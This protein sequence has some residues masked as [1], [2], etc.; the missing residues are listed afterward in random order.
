M[1]LPKVARRWYRL[2]AATAALQPPRHTAAVRNSLT[3]L[4]LTVPA[5]AL[6][7][8]PFCQIKQIDFF[9]SMADYDVGLGDAALMRRVLSQSPNICDQKPGACQRFGQLPQNAIDA[10]HFPIST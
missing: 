4:L 6:L 1:A 3:S 10:R 9:L 2:L 7:L 8:C 5:P